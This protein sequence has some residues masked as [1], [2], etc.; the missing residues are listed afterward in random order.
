MDLVWIRSFRI[1]QIAVFD[2]FTA[3]IGLY[4]LFAFFQFK[5]PSLWTF[6]FLFPIGI[7]SHYLFGVKTKLNEY[8]GI[9]KRN[10]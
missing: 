5:N 2:V 4:L 1:F 8:L 9:N 3:W 7:L 10:D 6:I